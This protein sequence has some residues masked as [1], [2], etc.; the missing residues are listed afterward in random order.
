MVHN[1]VFI[2]RSEYFRV[3]HR[4]II[5]VYIFHYVNCP[6]NEHHGIYFCISGEVVFTRIYIIF[7]SLLQ[8]HRLWQLG[9]MV[10]SRPFQ[11][12]YQAIFGVNVRKYSLLLYNKCLLLSHE[13]LHLS[14]FFQRLRNVKP[15][16]ETNPYLLYTPE[17]I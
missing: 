15:Y 4:K 6:C 17:S 14:V 11:E 16:A 2:N 9:R 13:L 12:Y 8:K 7:H 5:L 10:S 1:P 3:A